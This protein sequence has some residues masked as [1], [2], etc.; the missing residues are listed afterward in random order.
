MQ[1]IPAQTLA[2]PLSQGETVTV[3][4]TRRV[5]PGCGPQYEA[6]LA[7]L[8]LE[9]R[10]VPGYLGVTTHRPTSAGPLDYT[11][12]VR[13]SSLEHLQSF[14]KSELLVRHLA[15][16]RQ[17]VEGDAVWQRL[18]GLEFWFTPPA[19]MVVPQPSRPR[20]VVLMTAVV[21]ILVLSIG[22]LVNAGCDL[23]AWQTGWLVPRPARL[24]LTIA[25]EVTLMTYWLMPAITRRLAFW[26]YPKAKT[27]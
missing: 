1:T 8:Q 17:W 5:K 21:F 19:G 10:D 3:V 16:V 18:T 2:A 13:F 4:I 20:M 22:A 26:I 25:L 7:R 24:L 27:P 23:L 11:S 6:W 9:A 15:E 12:V 14:E